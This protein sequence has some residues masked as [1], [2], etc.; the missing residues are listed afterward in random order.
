MRTAQLERNYGAASRKI[1]LAKHESTNQSKILL[2]WLYLTSLEVSH[3]WQ[4]VND[5]PRDLGNGTKR[6]V[7]LSILHFNAG[8]QATYS[9]LC[10]AVGI[11]VRPQM[12]EG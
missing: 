3:F 9:K 2:Q 1:S 7:C 6:T 5:A 8:A 12:L 11:P 4:D 10:P